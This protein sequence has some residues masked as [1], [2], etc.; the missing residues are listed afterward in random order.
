MPSNRR[1]PQTTC[2]NPE[3]KVKYIPHDRRQRYCSKQCRINAGNN[4]KYL[5]NQTRYK[6]EKEIR[7][8]DKILENFLKSR[9]YQRNGMQISQMRLQDER[10][11]LN[12]CTQIEKRGNMYVRWYYRYGLEPKTSD[13]SQFGIHERSKF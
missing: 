7:R 4:R 3:C 9:E 12:L 10:V 2:I 11:D 1:Y 8:I 13:C 6:N 5:E